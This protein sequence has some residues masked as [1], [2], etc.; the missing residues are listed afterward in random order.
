M[1]GRNEK[2]RVGHPDTFAK[3]R[4]FLQ[5]F[6]IVILIVDR[7][8]SYLDDAEFQLSRCQLDERIGHLAIDRLLAKAADE[9]GHVAP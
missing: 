2:N 1:L 4:P 7:E 5:R 6:V 9:H 8:L 3:R